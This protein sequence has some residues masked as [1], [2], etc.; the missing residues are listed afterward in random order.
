[1]KE[2]KT[3]T[4]CVFVYV[5]VFVWAYGVVSHWGRYKIG[6]GSYEQKIEGVFIE[7]SPMLQNMDPFI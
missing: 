7:M 4:F 2:N 1:M 3:W 6:S 5:G